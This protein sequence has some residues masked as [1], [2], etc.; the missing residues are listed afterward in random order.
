MLEHCLRR[1]GGE[2]ES[3]RQRCLCAMTSV[4]SMD[5]L[6]CYSFDCNLFFGDYCDSPACT[7]GGRGRHCGFL[8]RALAAAA[9]D[10]SP[11]TSASASVGAG[12]AGQRLL[13]IFG[14]SATEFNKE[15]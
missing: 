1:G 8:Q 13:R 2:E 11:H 12:H 5:L 14:S 4:P 10:L 6:D 3:H 15:E 7:A 9:A